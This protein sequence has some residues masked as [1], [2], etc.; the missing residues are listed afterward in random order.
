[1]SPSLTDVSKVI[2]TTLMSRRENHK[3]CLSV[4]TFSLPQKNL[5][6]EIKKK[7]KILQPY[8]QLCEAAVQ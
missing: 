1:M 8:Q 4:V 2:R 3:F 5:S 7:K 6:F